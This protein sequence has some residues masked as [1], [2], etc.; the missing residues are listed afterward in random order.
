MIENAFSGIVLTA[1][2]F[3]PSIFTETWLDKNDIISA[4][5][6]EGTRVFSQVVAQFQAK[7]VRVLVTPPSMQISFGIHK[8]EG[9]FEVPCRI[10][11]RTIELLPETPYQ[12]LGLNFD[13]YVE[14]PKGQDLCT[15]SRALFGA[16]D[17]KLLQEFS[18]MDSRFGR[19]FSKNYGDARMKLD[20]K[21]VI[22]GP[23][24]KDLIQFSFNFHHDVSNIDLP[25][26]ARKLI[27][28]IGTWGSLRK[29]SE[30]LVSLGTKP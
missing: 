18:A 4:D 26:R 17:Y 3:N 13:F 1:Q 5:S 22:A 24:K 12:A 7:E 6:I 29:Y 14:P 25:E 9:E 28:Y 10:P 27:D 19:Y 16:G 11:I 21:P 15:Y 20:I 8:V 23:D 2:S 30:G